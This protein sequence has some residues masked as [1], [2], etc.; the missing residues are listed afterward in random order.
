M[1]TITRGDSPSVANKLLAR[2]G[3]GVMQPYWTVEEISAA[4][5]LP[6]L[7]DGKGSQPEA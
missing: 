2:C 5:A 1:D 7:S 6:F 4:L 3:S